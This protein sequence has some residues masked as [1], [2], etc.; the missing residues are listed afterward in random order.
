MLD[1]LERKMRTEQLFND[2]WEFSKQPLGSDLEKVSEV[3]TEWKKIDV[4][5][6]WMIYDATTFHKSSEG[7]YKKNL[8][9]ASFPT[10]TVDH[11]FDQQ[12]YILRFE[13]IYMDSSI[14]C[15]STED[16]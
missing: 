1:E 16:R 9:I 8:N 11:H 4:P 15:E 10:K 6:D 3:T 12:R 13:G 5:H 2:G 14:L 7:W